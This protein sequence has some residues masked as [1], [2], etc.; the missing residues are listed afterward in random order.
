MSRFVRSWSVISRSLPQFAPARCPHARRRPML[1]CLEDRA[2][3]S[4]IRI[5]V[6]SLADSGVGTLRSAIATADV[7]STTTNYVINLKTPGTITLESAL[8]DLS[9][10]ITIHGLGAGTSTV[11]RDTSL[12][13]P[14]R[15][16]T[17]DAGET[18][19]I[20]DLTIKGGNP[21]RGYGGGLDNF[22]TLAVSNSVFSGDSA[23]LGGGLNNAGT[24]TV[25]GSSCTGN[26]AGNAGGGGLFNTGTATVS[27]S[28]FTSNSASVDGGGIKNF[29]TPIDGGGN[30]FTGN[31]PNDVS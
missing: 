25:S 9:N 26:S 20:S 18:V 14:F 10:N 1:E 29:G 6:S 15:I 11:Q 12:S 28:S 16:F 22:G 21:G 24:A 13:T 30:T 5:T 31:S 23:F 17:V 27:D 4:T 2:L 7:G 8:P 3:L 19:N